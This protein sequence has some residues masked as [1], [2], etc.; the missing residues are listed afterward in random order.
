MVDYLAAVT[1]MASLKA[2]TEFETSN[3]SFVALHENWIGLFDVNGNLD[4]NGHRF[5]YWVGYWLGYGDWVRVRYWYFDWNLDGVWYLLFNVDGV[6]LLH[7]DW[8]RFRDVDWV[9]AVD[10]NG[11]WHFY[12]YGNLLFHWVWHRMGYRDG[13]FFVDGDTLNVSVRF[14]PCTTA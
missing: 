8:V 10:W 6:R 4:G 14:D 13:Y 12:W 7:E 9:R 5:V 3:P 1:D 11:V 2:T